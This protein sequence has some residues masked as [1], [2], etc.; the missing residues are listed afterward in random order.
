[1]DLILNNL[2]IPIEDDGMDAYL[3]AASQKMALGE[4]L[5]IV[6]I[7]SKALDIPMRY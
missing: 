6:H 3:Q 5:S 2:R 4:E 7:L 1:M